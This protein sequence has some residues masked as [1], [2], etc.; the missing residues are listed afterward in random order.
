[1][2]C[3]DVRGSI[4]CRRLLSAGVK[5]SWKLEVKAFGFALIFGAKDD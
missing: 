5:L 4:V 1:M 3:L 2:A